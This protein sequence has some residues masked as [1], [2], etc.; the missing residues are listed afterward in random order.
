ML[1]LTLVSSAMAAENVQVKVKGMVCSFCAQGLTKKFKAEPAVETVKV[2][3]SD[4]LI[5]LTLKDKQTMADEK[6]KKIIEEAGYDVQSI[7]RN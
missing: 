6:I 3:L 1:I 5:R 7:E 4:K 2:T